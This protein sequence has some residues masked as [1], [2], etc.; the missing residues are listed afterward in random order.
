MCTES[1]AAA[2]A[3]RRDVASRAA[4]AIVGGYAATSLVTA[5]LA[6]ALPLQRG[7]STTLAMLLSFFIFTGFVMGVFAARS[8]RRGWLVV[9]VPAAIAGALLLV[10]VPL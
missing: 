6:R 5:V 10:G 9:L 8:T 1:A 2:R 7:D 3:L 4:A